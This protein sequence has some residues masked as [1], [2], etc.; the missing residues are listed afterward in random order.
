MLMKIII[1]F[2]LYL[3]FVIRTCPERASDVGLN[4]TTVIVQVSN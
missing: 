4:Q 1:L 3:I 2:F